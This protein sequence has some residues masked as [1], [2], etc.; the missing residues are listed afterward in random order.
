MDD[1]I[2]R[3]RNFEN[4]DELGNGDFSLLHEA[5]AALEAALVD[6]ERYRWLR[7]RMAAEEITDET[8]ARLVLRTVGPIA[9]RPAGSDYYDELDAAIDQAREERDALAH[10]GE[11]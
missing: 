5:A 3:L 11:G 1:L 2:D 7:D 6:A 4:S 8:Y 9:K 10:G